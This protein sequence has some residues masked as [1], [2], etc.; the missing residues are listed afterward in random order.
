MYAAPNNLG[1]L[2]PI[3]RNVISPNLISLNK[4]R[5]TK[6]SLTPVS[7]EALPLIIEMNITISMELLT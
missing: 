3:M 2:D 4:F 7:K 6:I 5:L 1:Q